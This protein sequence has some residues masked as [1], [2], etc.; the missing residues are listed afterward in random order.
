MVAAVMILAPFGGSSAQSFSA[1][2]SPIAGVVQVLPQGESEWVNVVETTL[3][4]PGDQIRTGNDGLAR[5]NVVTG[6][7]VDIH[8]TTWVEINDLSLGEGDDSA[9]TYRLFQLV[10]RTYVYVDQELNP[11]DRVQVIYPTVGIVVT[12][13]EGTSF[14]NFIHPNLNAFVMVEEGEATAEGTQLPAVVVTPENALYVE[15]DLPQPVPEVCTLDLLETA[16]QN[17]E[18]TEIEA[19]DEGGEALRRHLVEAVTAQVNLEVRPYMRALLGLPPVDISALNQQEDE[20]EL[21]E[22]LNAIPTFDGNGMELIEFLANYR[23]FWQVYFTTMSSAPLAQETCGNLEQDPGETA[24]NCPTDFA[25]PQPCGNSLCEIDRMIQGD[26]GES[27]INCPA[28]CLPYPDL[29]RSC[30]ALIS[31][32]FG[33]PPPQVPTPS[34]VGVGGTPLRATLGG[35]SVVPAGTGDPDGS[36]LAEFT[37]NQGQGVICFGIGTQNIDPITGSQIHEGGA[38]TN[39]GVVVDFGNQRSGC[40]SGVPRNLVMDIRQNPG[41]YYLNVDTTAFPAGAIRGQL[42]R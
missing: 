41:D 37:L 24:Q 31:G 11:D 36:G 32:L 3:I 26:L 13:M 34:G 10:G 30:A 4:N 12:G 23:E 28:D 7:S 20:E 27:V 39:G 33:A 16:V 35:G 6:I 22:L 8:P 40:V 15:F 1:T 5:L 17:V 38:G 21:V 29:A 2:L 42:S 18:I 19:D 14:F 9:L 25:D